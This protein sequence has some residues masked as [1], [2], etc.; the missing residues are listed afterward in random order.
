MLYS[1]YIDLIVSNFSL[2]ASIAL[3][4]N[5][6]RRGKIA[7]GTIGILVPTIKSSG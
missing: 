3:T 6:A 2:S 1:A 7:S 4:V 5:A